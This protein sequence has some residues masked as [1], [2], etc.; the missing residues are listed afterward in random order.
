MD[1][2]T[3]IVAATGLIAALTKLLAELR[4]WPRKKSKAN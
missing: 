4:R 1:P 3:T 2:A